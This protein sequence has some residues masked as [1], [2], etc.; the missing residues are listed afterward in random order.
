MSDDDSNQTIQTIFN[1]YLIKI[2][3]NM[4]YINIII[5]NN[6]NYNI[7]ESK[8]NFE[9][10]HQYKLLS[11]NYTIEE[12]IEF[13]NNLIEKQIIKIEENEKDLKLILMSNTSYPNVELI[14]KKEN[15]IE[16]LM[17]E[18]KDIK[19]ENKILKKNYKEIKNKIEL[20]ENNLNKND[21]NIIKKEEDKKLNIRIE[22]IEKDNKELKNEIKIINEELKNKKDELNKE[23]KL[24]IKEELN[25]IDLN[26]KIKLIEKNNEEFINKIIKEK[27][28]NEECINTIEKEKENNE[29]KVKKIQLTKCNLKNINSIQPHKHW[30]M[31]VSTFPSGNIISV[32]FDKSIIIYDIHLNI[33]QNIQNAHKD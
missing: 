18:I 2:S 25:K 29:D 10:L 23:I 8:F 24:R 5:Q 6:N 21:K 11:G 15:I 7:Y 19:N 16:K 32:S 12:M 30:I 9:Y 26:N 17:K 27:L 28:N 14:L 1:E 13:M 22:L 20:I 33:L 31:S 3:S 4:D